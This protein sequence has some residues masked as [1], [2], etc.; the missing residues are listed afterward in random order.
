MSLIVRMLLTWLLVLAIPAQAGAAAVMAFCNPGQHAPSVSVLSHLDT[1]PEHDHGAH[2]HQASLTADADHHTNHPTDHHTDHHADHKCSACAAC[3]S[4]SA[5][6]NSVPTIAAPDA[7]PAVFSA[8][9]CTV[10]AF[11]AD[12]PERP[13]RTFLA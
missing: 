8:V 9:A 7:S 6:L 5:L 3:C 13:P 4:V 11:I 10:D 1:S 12:G 2:E